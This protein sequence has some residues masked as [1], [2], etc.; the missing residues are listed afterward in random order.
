MIK[1]KKNGLILKPRDIPWV[2]THL[3]VPTAHKLDQGKIIVFFAG[4]NYQN[5]SDIGYFV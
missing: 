3:W 5:E 1:F 2:K 4:R